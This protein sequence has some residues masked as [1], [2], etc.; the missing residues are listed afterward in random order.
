M[1]PERFRKRIIRQ[2]HR[3]HPGIDRMKSLAR[4]FVHWP[5]ID[6]DIESFARQCHSCAAAA[7]LLLNRGNETVG[8]DPVDGYYYLVVVVAYT[9]WPEI[10]RTLS[11]TST[12]KLAFLQ[13]T[14]A[15]YDNPPTLVSD[16]GTQFISD[17]FKQ[18]CK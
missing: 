5:N 15:R 12:A 11:T 3:G 4:S 17:R 7:R 14:F 6:D 16:N 10:F 9:K 1:V 8:Q 2:L 18:F 13:A